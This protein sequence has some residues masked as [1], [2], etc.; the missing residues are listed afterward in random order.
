MKSV[1]VA[2]VLFLTLGQSTAAQVQ[3]PPVQLPPGACTS[4]QL[5]PAFLAAQGAAGTSRLFNSVAL[6]ESR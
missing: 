1:L 6:S 5:A 2:L 3:V 4:A